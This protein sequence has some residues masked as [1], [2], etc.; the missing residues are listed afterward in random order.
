MDRCVFDNGNRCA[1]LETLKCENCTFRKTRHELIEGRKR[2][3]QLLEKL[4]ADQLEHIESKYY[5]MRI[6]ETSIW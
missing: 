1:A 4:P 5:R 3:R 6:M 2:S